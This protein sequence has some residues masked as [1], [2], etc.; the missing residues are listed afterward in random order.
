MKKALLIFALI[1][2]LMLSSCSKNESAQTILASL[3]EVSGENFEDGGEVYFS[4]AYEGQIGYFSDTIKALM[5]GEDAAKNIFP[6]TES[7]AVFVSSREPSEIAVFKCYSA[8]DTDEIERT[9]LERAD[10]IKVMLHNTRWREK[11]EDISVIVHK[12][13]V[14]LLF[15]ENTRSVERKFKELT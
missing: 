3:L 11:S 4:D 10:E 7:C 1:F 6:L 13:Y 2:G 9:L 5:Y 8:S 14:L 12:K 15:A